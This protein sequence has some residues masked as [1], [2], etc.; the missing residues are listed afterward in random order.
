MDLKQF[1]GMTVKE[2][3]VV[4]MK[5]VISFEETDETLT[6]KSEDKY[7]GIEFE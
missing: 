5:L 7:C 2:M 4:D 1:T 3:K 6:V